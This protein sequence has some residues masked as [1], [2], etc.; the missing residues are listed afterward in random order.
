MDRQKA[1]EMLRANSIS[2]VLAVLSL[3][4]AFL[5]WFV[6]ETFSVHSPPGI[7]LY[8]VGPPEFFPLIY[9]VTD[10]FGG[11][12]IPSMPS[13]AALVFIFGAVIAWWS[14][15]GGAL[16]V[17]SVY[18]IAISVAR[19]DYLLYDGI[20]K[21]EY[22]LG[23]GFHIGFFI[24]L[25]TVFSLCPSGRSALIRTIRTVCRRLGSRVA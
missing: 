6:R 21:A 22:S 13:I 25:G 14:P 8:F 20:V 5:P 23:L 7:V 17:G 9:A 12:G 1:L 10:F 3:V 24:A 15:I 11:S 2:R 18:A 4:S 19:V 16:Q